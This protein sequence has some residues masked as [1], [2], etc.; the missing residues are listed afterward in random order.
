MAIIT[1]TTD[2]GLKDYYVSTI[3]GAI[4]SQLPEVNIVD[5]SH[6]VLPFD[7]SQAAFIL[8]NSY[9]SFPKGS[10]HIIGVNAEAD[11]N[12]IL[13]GLYANG[14]YFFGAD[15]GI[16]SLLFDFKP[17][18]IVELNIRQEPGFLTFPLKDVLVK[19]AC[20]AARGGTL[21]VIGTVIESVKERTLLKPFGG[22]N[23]IRGIISYI[24]SYENMIT[25]IDAQLFKETGKGF[26]FS[27]DMPYNRNS[28]SSISKVYND[29]PPGEMLALF[30][31]AGLLEIAINKGNAAGL[32]SLKLGDPITVN[33]NDNKNS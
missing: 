2:L 26:P 10:I 21:E 4:L 25:N 20:H 30:N 9:N 8:K 28:I 27:I 23:I 33:F 13:V 24:D 16:F 14:H 11:E 18:L 3:K 1:L 7:I 12:T 32:L 17:D 22:N 19:A 31:S 29:V 6:Q 15:N 5:I